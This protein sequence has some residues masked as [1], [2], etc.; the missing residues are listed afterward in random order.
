MVEDSHG[1]HKTVG[2]ISST[3][4]KLMKMIVRIILDYY[5]VL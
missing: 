3:S 5:P 1:V 2:S 4:E